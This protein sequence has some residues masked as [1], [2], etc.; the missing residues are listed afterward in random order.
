MKRNDKITFISLLILLLF[1][2]PNPTFGQ[3]NIV[4]RISEG[5]YEGEWHKG[6]P[7]GKGKII[8]KSGD[9]YEGDFVKGKREGYGVYTFP[10]GEKY[11]GYWNQNHQHGH[12]VYYFA[13]KDK[14]DGMW[15]LDYQ[16]GQGKMYYHNGDLYEGT[17]NQ[18]HIQGHG[19][20]YFANKDKY[21]G[22]WDND[23]RHGQG[24]MYYHNGDTYE[25]MW[26]K[27]MRH[28]YG[29]YT[30]ASG[31]S[32][33]GQWTYD[34]MNGHGTMIT[35]DGTITSGEWK[36]DRFISPQNPEENK[37]GIQKPEN[38]PVE[39]RQWT[40]TGFALKN[41]YIVTNYHVAGEAKTIEIFGI[42]GDFTKGYKAAVVGVDRVSDLALLKLSDKEL[43][44]YDTPPFAFK[45]SM[46]D[47]GENVYVLGYPLI[48][49]MG[50]EIKL[51]NGIVSSR[52][53]YEGDV[54]T[55]QI[56]VPVQPGNSGGPMFDMKGNLVGIICAKHAD[57]E[58][59]SYAI[60]TSYLKNLVESVASSAIL[61]TISTVNGK[62]LKEQVK[63][64]KNFVYMIKCSYTSGR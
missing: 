34:K 45:S 4:H 31:A 35:K 11:E 36:N 30:Y 38:P 50:K 59:A 39:I 16:H 58:N 42:K 7:H 61:P 9:I 40:G 2:F 17:W 56:S 15:Y 37:V 51:T 26:V 23:C 47:V 8:Y 28:G 10:D 13:N 22:T 46:V 25:G 32:Y 20:Y 43:S 41:G 33:R 60:K 57:A 21:D 1:L 3:K 24:K 64:I 52:S 14:Y 29:K 27:N 44:N 55:Y 49:T 5:I 53:G 62:E 54:T 6:K 18:D 12:G 63:Q 48:Q 19:V